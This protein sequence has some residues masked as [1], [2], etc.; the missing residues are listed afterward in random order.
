[1]AS[2]VARPQ[3]LADQRPAAA[4]IDYLHLRQL[5]APKPGRDAARKGVGAE[6]QTTTSSVVAELP[7]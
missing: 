1:M 6:L 3:R 7:S 5:G 2:G 4:W